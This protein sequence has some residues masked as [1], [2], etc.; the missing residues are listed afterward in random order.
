[1]YKIKAELYDQVFD[2]KKEDGGAASSESTM[3]QIMTA[4]VEK[5]HKDYKEMTT[6][7]SQRTSNYREKYLVQMNLAETQKFMLQE[8]EQRATEVV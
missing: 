6:V 7:E 2:K 5:L 1:M 4:E 8:L 3:Q